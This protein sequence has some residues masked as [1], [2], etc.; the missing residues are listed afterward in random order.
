M[1]KRIFGVIIGIVGTWFW[2]ALGMAIVLVGLHSCG[3]AIA[4][5][6]C[7]DAGFEH[8]WVDK[9]ILPIHCNTNAHCSADSF[10]ECANCGLRKRLKETWVY[11]DSQVK[12]PVD[13]HCE[14]VCEPMYNKGSRDD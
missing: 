6:R 13:D 11:D 1:I 3:V 8:A 9:T 5:N 2:L 4:G 12:P 14:W 10:Y 7:E